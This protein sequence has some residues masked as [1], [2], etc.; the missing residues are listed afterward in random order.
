VG[1]PGFRPEAVR[2]LIQITDADNQAGA[3][4]G[5]SAGNVSSATV[6]GNAL[7]SL[8]IKFVGLYGTDDDG[9]GAPCGTPLECANQLG[10]ASGTVDG[11]GNP[12]VFPI[13]ND[14]TTLVATTRQA[15]LAL[16]RGVPLNVVIQATDLPDDDGDALAFID[17]LEVNVS[18]GDCTA[19]NP[20]ADTNGDGRQD[21][22]PSLLGGTPVCWDVHPILTNDFRPATE[23][24]QVFKARLTV[25]GDG[26]PLDSRDV[27]FLIPPVI[28]GPGGPG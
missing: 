23:V 8:G 1:C 19:V 6:A 10:T 25:F 5:G 11:N 9:S 15:V 3:S 14:G 12:I 22:F 2:I 21:A 4:C 26:S 7:S 13:G 24:P 20:T 27:F 16:V 18:G 17:Y 28:T